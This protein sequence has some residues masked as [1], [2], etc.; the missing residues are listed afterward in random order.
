[1]E[2][3]LSWLKESDISAPNISVKQTEYAGYGL[4]A[5]EKIAANSIAA[6]IPNDMMITPQ[7][8][9][10]QLSKSNAF[11]TD[12]YS[13]K[14]SKH[15]KEMARLFLIYY[16]FFAT[17]E[18]YWKSY[19]DILPD[20]DFFK[21]HHVLFNIA[22]LK[23]TSLENA[24]NAKLVNL[25]R[26]LNDIQHRA[27]LQSEKASSSW[28]SDISLD[29]YLWADCIF[30]SRVIGLED[31]HDNCMALVPFIDFA[32][33]SINDS[34]IR[35]QPDPEHHGLNLI[36]SPANTEKIIQPDDELLLS[37]GPKSNQELLFIHGFCIEGNPE[38]SCIT[39]SA[40]PF[41]SQ[42]EEMYKLQWLK[43]IA[44]KPVLTLKK[45]ENG[46]A[47]IDI[48]QSGWEHTSIII[49]YLIALDEDQG[50]RYVCH[51]DHHIQLLLEDHPINTLNELEEAV[52]DR[53]GQKGDILP[54]IQ[55]RTVMLLIDA[56]EYQYSKI[57]TVHNDLNTPL[58]HHVSIYRKEE[59]TLLESSL[60]DLLSLQSY[61]MKDP[62]VLSFL[63]KQ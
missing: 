8:V 14:E 40:L 16:R 46:N 54:I 60:E 20:I 56:L 62:I 50:L 34:N 51:N 35:W 33:H 18:Y 63:E 6:Y 27:E 47:I 32:N 29:M 11:I 61:L 21:E 12:L 55:L 19:I 26:D 48:M 57:C 1:M 22:C 28:I 58:A 25:K 49:L 41:L 15:E 23:G 13:K 10:E 7:K 4:F 42:E 39:L 36:A 53:H 30:W 24:T 43:Q 3:F 52:M 5:T 44:A 38:P 2:T 31:G 45:R 17:S 59:Q 37:Y 9:M